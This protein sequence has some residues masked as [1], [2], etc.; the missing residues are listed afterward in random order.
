MV[1]LAGLLN[2]F[3]GRSGAVEQ[4]PDASAVT[5]RMIERAQAV[6]RAEL[7]PPYLY[8]KRSLLEE[9][10]ASG[11]TL[12][13]E[14]K[15]YQVRLIAGFPFNRLVKIQGRDLTADEL[16]KEQQKEEKFQK[17]FVSVDAKQMAARKEG[18][19]TGRL[20]D[21]YQFEVKERIILSN[22]ATLVLT[23]T[24]KTGRLPDQTI[25]DKL[26]NR[27]AGTVWVD[28]AD[29]D[30]ARLEV[31]LLEPFSLGW[32]G[33]LGSLSQCELSL[34]RQRQP[35]GVWLNAKQVLLIQ[36]RK[37][38]STRHF[39]TTEDSGNFKPAEPPPK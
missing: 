9:L 2:L 29:A 8:E 1:L 17:K 11:Q 20:L 24:P 38:T 35:D 23:F 21:R 30:A 39:R 12:K 16:K 32:L 28:E 31:R 14:E 10:D 18:W 4:L 27:L 25:Q 19:V 6:A 33:I 15:I 22:R 34:D 3:P 13:S 7:G 5:R 37:L 26:L 36:Y